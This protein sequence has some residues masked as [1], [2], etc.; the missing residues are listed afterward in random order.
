MRNGDDLNVFAPYAKHDEEREATQQYALSATEVRRTDIRSLCDQTD[1]PI[2]LPLKTSRRDVISFAVP[3][4]GSLRL[5]GSQWM[6]FDRE[7][8]H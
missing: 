4:L 3:S 1:R 5:G 6:E 2:E 7:L 8:G